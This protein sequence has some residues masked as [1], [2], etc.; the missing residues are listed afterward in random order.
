MNAIV[1]YLDERDEVCVSYAREIGGAVY[2]LKLENKNS[3]DEMNFEEKN[4]IEEIKK[5]AEKAQ[6]IVFRK[7]TYPGKL[8]LDY[9]EELS[10]FKL[11]A[12]N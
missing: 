11:L 2:M 4:I 1:V 6:V 3:L 7:G 8:I 10:D 5:F 12:V 9:M